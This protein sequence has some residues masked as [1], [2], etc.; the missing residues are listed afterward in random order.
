MKIAVKKTDKRHTASNK[1]QYYV[2]IHPDNFRERQLVLEKFYELR[3]WCWE[4]WGPSRE[5][6]ENR[7][8]TDSWAG[9]DNSHWS[10]VNDKWRARIY[11]TTK[12]EAALFT[13]RWA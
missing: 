2:V 10:W 6:N 9:D 7:A 4:T 12:D 13:L 11:L 8:T 5:A 1:H 3:A